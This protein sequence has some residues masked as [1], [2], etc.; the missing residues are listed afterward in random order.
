MAHHDLKILPPYF[1]AVA[2]GK[3]TFEIRRDD[4]GFQ[5][6]DAVT[7]KEYEAPTA[8]TNG[9]YTGRNLTR[10]IGYVTAFEQQLGWVVFSLIPYE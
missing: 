10:R 1:E 8:T 2:S 7:L 3:K 9:K 6:G 4:R 5:A